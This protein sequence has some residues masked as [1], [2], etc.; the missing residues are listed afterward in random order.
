MTPMPN[1]SCEL[2][3]TLLK[4][5]D[6]PI[7][8]VKLKI[9]SGSIITRA[10]QCLYPIKLQENQPEDQPKAPPSKQTGGPERANHSCTTDSCW[11]AITGRRLRWGVCWEYL[12]TESGSKTSETYSSGSSQLTRRALDDDCLIQFTLAVLYPQFCYL[13]LGAYVQI[14]IL[15]VSGT[16]YLWTGISVFLHWNSIL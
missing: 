2:W 9:P 11:R 3:N 5:R 15:C 16:I 12:P 10:I 7:G 13:F 4:G 1:A 8:L 14:A 6:G